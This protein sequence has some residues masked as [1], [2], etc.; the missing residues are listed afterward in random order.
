MSNAHSAQHDMI[1]LAEGMHIEALAYP[2]GAVFRHFQNPLGNA[3]IFRARHLDVEGG[4]R[5][6][7][8]LQPQSFDRLCLI[9]HAHAGTR[10]FGEG[11]QQ[12]LEDKHL[13]RKSAP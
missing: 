4:T 6:Q 5:Y 7:H 2:H 9:G 10:G 1:A 12:M 13:G 11:T 3:Q 8:R